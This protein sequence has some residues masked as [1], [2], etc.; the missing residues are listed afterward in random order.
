MFTIRAKRSYT[1]LYT[2]F[3][4]IRTSEI[5]TIRTQSCV[6]FLSQTDSYSYPSPSLPQHT[7]STA[8]LAEN[9]NSL[10]SLS[11]VL[12]TTFL[13]LPT[14]RES[15]PSLV[16][17]THDL[18]HIFNAFRIGKCQIPV[19][20]ETSH[21]VNNSELGRRRRAPSFNRPGEAAHYSCISKGRTY[22]IVCSVADSNL[23]PQLNAS[24][25][26]LISCLSYLDPEC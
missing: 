7:S 10:A 3:F 20:Q 18:R 23:I 17:P 9:C 24:L 15:Q 4:L 6:H 25:S 1:S 13:Q 5:T 14:T 22:L 26:C 16:I 2:R 8:R 19:P 12:N 21:H 11:S